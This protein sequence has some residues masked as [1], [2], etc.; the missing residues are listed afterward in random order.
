M[1]ISLSSALCFFLLLALSA[2]MAAGQNS[3]L[4]FT[5]VNKDETFFKILH[6]GD[7]EVREGKAAFRVER[8]TPKMDMPLEVVIMIDVSGSQ[9][10]LIG[11]ERDTAAYFIDHILKKG[12]DR[13]AIVKFSNAATLV[14]DLTANLDDAKASVAGIRVYGPAGKSVKD[15]L[16]PAPSSPVTADQGGALLGK[17]NSRDDARKDKDLRPGST[18]SVWRSTQRAIEV[19]AELKLAGARRAIILI[20]DGI[21]TN[22]HKYLNDA[23]EQSI[24]SQI[25]IYP[26]AVSNFS[27]LTA[28][29]GLWLTEIANESG[30]MALLP[31]KRKSNKFAVEMGPLEQRLRNYYEVEVSGDPSS[32]KGKIREIDIRIINETL[33]KVKIRTLYP[34]GFALN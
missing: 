22:G 31:Q 15:G 18:T 3:T 24:R 4:W 32:Q 30:G 6:A 10:D 16:P 13:V 34:Q 21:D 5:A 33:R 1:K 17:I 7:I 20:T 29:T 28:E 23:V 9:D 25:P 19:F 14:H 27:I 2:L 26:I 11:V 12:R 8:L